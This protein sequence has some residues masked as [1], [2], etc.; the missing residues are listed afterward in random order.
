MGKRMAS[1]ADKLK[2]L[3]Q[4]PSIGD[5]CIID[6]SAM[7]TYVEIGPFNYI[8]NSQIGDYSYTGPNCYLQNTILG[9]FCSIAASVRMGPTD[10]PME[11]PTQHHMTYRRSLYGFGPDD[12]S[13]FDQRQARQLTVGHDVWMGHGVIVMPG[14]R[15]GTGAVIG[16]GSVVTRD[17]PPYAIAVG[18]P[19][20]VIKFRFDPETRQGL[21]STCWWEWDHETLNQRMAHLSGSVDQFIEM[22][23]SGA[24]S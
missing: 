10:H 5:R 3:D 20:R 7:G 16:A 13:F 22:Y 14:L 19:A 12:Q 15:I 6:D 17:I 9:N 2:V 1:S 4:K 8:E 21:L 18:N 24:M 23:G 11:R